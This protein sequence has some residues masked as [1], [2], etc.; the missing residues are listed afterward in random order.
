MVDGGR[1]VSSKVLVIGVLGWSVDS[2]AVCF[3]LFSFSLSLLIGIG[4]FSSVSNLS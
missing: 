3:G 2:Y 1:A 4:S